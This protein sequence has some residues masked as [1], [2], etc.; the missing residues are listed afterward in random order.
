MTETELPWK[1]WGRRIR[2]YALAVSLAAAMVSWSLLGTKDGGPG[3]LLDHTTAGLIIGIAGAVATICLW[4]GFWAKSDRLM[5]QGLLLTTGV[6]AAR[7]IFI[8]LD[9]S[10]FIQSVGLSFCWV[11]ASAGAYLLET[12]TG[13]AARRRGRK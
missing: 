12:T 13:E 3:T 6:F 9:S 11:V 10:W 8:A 1:L 7:G 4:W 2:P 5:Q